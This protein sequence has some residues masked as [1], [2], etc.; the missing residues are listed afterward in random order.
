MSLLDKALAQQVKARSYGA[1][2]PDH[3]ELA[4]AFLKDQVGHV[5]VRNVLGSGYPSILLRSIREAY[6]QGKITL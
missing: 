6:R 3:L 2:T 1:I 5:Q 4:I